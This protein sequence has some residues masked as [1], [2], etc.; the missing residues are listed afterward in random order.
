MGK[1]AVV[2][3]NGDA[4]LPAT[5]TR[6]KEPDGPEARFFVGDKSTSVTSHCYEKFA[7]RE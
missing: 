7:W 3:N 1:A 5:S 2:T 6:L 4:S